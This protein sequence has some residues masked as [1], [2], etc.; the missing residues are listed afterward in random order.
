MIRTAM[1]LASAIALTSPASAEVIAIEGAKVH[2]RPGETLDNATVL[3][4]DG[5]I[6]AA[7][8][9]VVVPADARRIDGSGKQVT[10]GFVDAYSR[11]GLVEV[12]AVGSTDEG[13]FSRDLEGHIHA[14]YRVL[15][16]YNPRSV[17]IPVARTG[18]I[19]SAVAVPSGGLV[20]GSAAWLSLGETGAV[21]RALVR[22]PAAMIAVLGEGAI[23]AGS[24]TRGLAALRLRELLGDASEYAGRRAA[25]ERGQSRQ[26]AAE[27]LALEAM[28]PVLAGEIPLV[29]T[30]H[31]ASDI[32]VAIA[33]AEDF[34]LRLVIEGATE[35]WM[36]AEELAA[37]DI[38]VILDPIANL[39]SSFDRVHVRD[40]AAAVL[41]EAGV[42]VAFSL[43]GRAS[44]AR[45]LRQVA[46]N[47]VARGVPADAAL[48]A[49]TTVPAAI[50]GVTDRGAIAPGYR[51]DVV[52][53][54]GDPFELDSHVEA[55]FIEGVETSLRTR[56]TELT[57]RYLLRAL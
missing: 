48:A 7:G 28:Q 8:A 57:E 51:A 43:S 49:L 19:T 47:A 24:G 5:M 23:S 38:P 54:S 18:G 27:R 13:R 11:L 25:Y 45:T 40:D 15:D 37:A 10:A 46:G 2:V 50:Y 53:W 16:G 35:A 32:L 33:L 41:A 36:I 12:N 20:S 30:A 55:M 3:L 21:S 1:I 39:P 29:I 17:T 22:A 26:L 52:L 31:R 56:Q 6:E 9:N 34:D 14:A 4:R 44:A 42:R